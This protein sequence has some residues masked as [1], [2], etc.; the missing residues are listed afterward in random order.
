VTL[1]R[2]PSFT[3]RLPSAR[4]LLL[5]TYRKDGTP[6]ATPVWFIRDGSR[7]LV[8]T[9]ARSGKVRRIRRDRQVTVQTCTL[10]GKPTS[11]AEE[12]T[13]SILPPKQ[14]PAVQRLLEQRYGLIMWL[15]RAYSRQSATTG[16]PAHLAIDLGTRAMERDGTPYR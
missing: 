6:V 12:A 11:A 13:A 14:G 9:D 3:Q 10:R 2:V 15:Y 7:L 8:W 1:T 16:T 5:T 4:Y